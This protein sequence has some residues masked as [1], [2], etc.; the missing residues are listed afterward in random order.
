MTVLAAH[1]P[2]YF[3]WIGYLDKM[4][5]ADVFIISDKSQLSLKSPMRR[6]KILRA[7]GK[8]AMLTLSIADIKSHER[9]TCDDLLLADYDQNRA[10]HQG[11]IRTNYRH[12]PFYAEIM[13]YIEEYFA[14]SRVRYVDAALE[15]ILLLRHLYG[16][17][18]PITLQ[19][20]LRYDP[21]LRNN[22]L[23]IDFCAQMGADRYL[24][25]VGAQSYMDMGRYRDNGIRV[26]YQIFEYPSYP[27][28][29]LDL[30][31]PNLSALDML[32]QLG[33]EGARKR[34]RENMRFEEWLDG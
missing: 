19:S 18:T 23:I 12:A 16:I 27:Q 25:G 22:D 26:A 5:K 29:G 8:E 31:V 10:S 30:F 11:V 15:S 14:K 32:F 13:P 6:N 1:Q 7:D 17:E 34:F 21:S 4:A 3:P 9:K 20:D 2:H 28:F 24:S 33:I